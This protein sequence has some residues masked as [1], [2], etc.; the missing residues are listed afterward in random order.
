MF[1]DTERRVDFKV[2]A[3]ILTVSLVTSLLFLCILMPNSNHPDTV[4]AFSPASSNN[5]SLTLSTDKSSYG[6]GDYVVISGTVD[7]PV[8]EKTVR[9]D[10]YDPE[11]KVFQPYNESF[12]ES[13]P[14]SEAYPRLSNLQ[15]HP[16]DRGLF[17]YLFVLD[18]TVSGPIIKGIYKIEANYEGNTTEISFPVR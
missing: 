1:K 10:V 12:N 14:W 18:N 9:L 17:S 7:K 5:N 16:N 3:S 4:Y 11:G 8:E 2:L 6:I 15:V 13:T